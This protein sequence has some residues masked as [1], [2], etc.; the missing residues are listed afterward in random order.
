MGFNK[1]YV[2]YQSTFKAIQTNGI[3]KYYGKAD[4]LI[5]EDEQSHFVYDLFIKGSDN[6]EILQ[7]LNNKTN[8]ED[9]KN[10]TY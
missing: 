5:F 9:N 4:A 7:I 8:M 2:N 1:R 3:E 6:Q 10:E